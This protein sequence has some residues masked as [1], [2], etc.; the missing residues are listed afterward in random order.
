MQRIHTVKQIK[1][2]LRER[3]R[4]KRELERERTREREN[5]R[6]RERTRERE[7]KIERPQL[8]QL[9]NRVA[10]C[11]CRCGCGGRSSS[12]AYILRDIQAEVTELSVQ[13]S[14]SKLPHSG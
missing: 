5:E 2:S 9:P 3:V 14:P 7:R 4:R 10:R 8:P 11:R 12:S 1:N 6:E 13:Q